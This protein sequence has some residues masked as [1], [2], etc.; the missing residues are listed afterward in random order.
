MLLARLAH[1]N[2]E[3]LCVVHHFS[4][5]TLAYV[6]RCADVLV[7]H[8]GLSIKFTPRVPFVRNDVDDKILQKLTSCNSARSSL[9]VQTVN[10]NSGM[11]FDNVGFIRDGM[12]DQ[13][14]P[15]PS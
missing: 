3:L 13:F 14:D 9:A 6:F 4:R 2:S 8:G 11:S 10:S 15:Q 1:L 5:E 12:D 7:S